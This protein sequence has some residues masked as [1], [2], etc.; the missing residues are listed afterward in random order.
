ME[1][2]TPNED[3]R[4]PRL[5]EILN[6]DNALESAAEEATE[7]LRIK[8]T[9]KEIRQIIMSYLEAFGISLKNQTRYSA[10]YA[11]DILDSGTF[12]GF[13]QGIR[14]RALAI[15]DYDRRKIGDVHL[16][17]RKGLEIRERQQEQGS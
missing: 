8:E 4:G 7:N 12:V 14:G 6:D 9:P 11:R 17:Y 1:A 10:D 15:R 3:H 2:I 5:D 13:Y 16:G